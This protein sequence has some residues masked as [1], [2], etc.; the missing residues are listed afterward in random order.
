[1]HGVIYSKCVKA[2]L[3]FCSS[4]IV[5]ILSGSEFQYCIVLGKN[6]YL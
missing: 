1:M 4:L 6:E 3:D 2:N 5:S